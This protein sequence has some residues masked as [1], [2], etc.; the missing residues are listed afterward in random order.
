LGQ[1]NG[2]KGFSVVMYIQEHST[3]YSQESWSIGQ[4]F[5]VFVFWTWYSISFFQ[6]INSKSSGFW[7]LW[8]ELIMVFFFWRFLKSSN[9][10]STILKKTIV[11][12]KPKINF[13]RKISLSSIGNKFFDQSLVKN[14]VTSWDWLF[15]SMFQH[16]KARTSLKKV[17]HFISD[18]FSGFVLIFRSQFR[19]QF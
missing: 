17:S 12:Q 18:F 11:N 1:T 15:A 8:T 16:T 2:I 5:C 3:E 13:D 6:L 7:I 9:N 10:F 19:K 14:C 4:I